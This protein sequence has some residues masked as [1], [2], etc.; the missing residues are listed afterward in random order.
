MPTPDQTRAHGS[1]ASGWRGSRDDDVRRGAQER[2]LGFGLAGGE[3]LS[4]EVAGIVGVLEDPS[5]SFDG[6]QLDVA[7]P[8]GLGF[9]LELVG[10]VEACGREELRSRVDTPVP[11]PTSRTRAGGDGSSRSNSSNVRTY[12]SRGRPP[13]KSRSSSNPSS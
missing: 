6:E 8:D 10:Q 5:W 4:L 13:A 12:S 3:E 2:W 9:T 7:K 1:P 11:P